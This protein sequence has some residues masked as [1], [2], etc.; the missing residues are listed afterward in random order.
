MQKKEASPVHFIVGM[1]RAGTTW[2]SFVLNQHEE[3]C[4]FGETCFF[5]RNN[6]GKSQLEIEEL[7]L[8]SKMNVGDAMPTIC[9]KNGGVKAVIKNKIQTL[10]DQK[11]PIGEKAFFLELVDAVLQSENKK[12][13]IE[14]TPHHIHYVDKI[15][16]HFPDSKLI[17]MYRDI[18]GFML[19]YKYQYARYSDKSRE[20]FKRMYHPLACVWVYRKYQKA[21]EHCSSLPN[22]LMIDYEDLKKDNFPTA[23][24][25]YN[26][27][28]LELPKNINIEKV[29]SSFEK[30]KENPSL[31]LDDEL[32]ISLFYKK[33]AK[34]HLNIH[35][36]HILLASMFKLLPWLWWTLK[37]LTKNKRSRNRIKHIIKLLSR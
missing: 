37:R 33:D 15:R 5:G 30:K 11:E 31:S 28:E 20:N 8:L 35:N 36:I 23:K 21:I 29:N 27:L 25:A 24:R 3:V 18:R 2:M 14:K 7:K 6:L 10:I 26:F 4:V 16:K 1:S 13:A 19:S 17:V 22:T 34:K 9:E 32:W 12:I